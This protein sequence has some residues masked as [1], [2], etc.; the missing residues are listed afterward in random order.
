MK[1]AS[2]LFM[3]AVLFCPPGAHAEG[4]AKTLYACAFNAGGWNRADWTRVGNPG[5]DFGDFVQE[6]G[7]IANTV[8]PGATHKEL[9]GKL[10]AK[11][12]ASMVYRERIAGDVAATATM[13]FADETAPLI[14]LAENLTQNADGQKQLGERFEVVI[15]DKGVNI[16]R[17]DTKDGKLICRLA[18]FARFPLEKNTRY[19]LEV[20]KIGKTLTVSVAGHTFGCTDD[21]LPD[22]FYVGI[23]GCEGLNH[24]YDF[25]LRPASGKP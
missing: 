19:A 7:R 8:P 18:V 24:F 21:A 5:M 20:K 17:H 15:Y 3:L 9:R 13:D 23:T 2:P 11:T 10:A 4:P 6:E 22:S 16:W 14:V 12:F 25:A 1:S